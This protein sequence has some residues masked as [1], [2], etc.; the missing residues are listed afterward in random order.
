MWMTIQIL[1]VALCVFAFTPWVVSPKVYTPLILGLPYSLGAGILVS[2]A[3]L[4]LVILGAMFA[5]SVSGE[6]E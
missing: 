4:G 1:T 5:P 2:V 6:K 3:L